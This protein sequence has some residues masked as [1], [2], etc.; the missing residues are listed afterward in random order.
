MDISLQV[1]VNWWE[2][3]T[4]M[5]P[6]PPG[7]KDRWQRA[8][9]PL[10]SAWAGGVPLEFTALYGMRNYGN[11]SW[12]ITHTDRQDTHALSL[13]LNLHQD[14]TAHWPFHIDDVNGTTHEVFLE[15]GEMI[16]YESAACTHGRPVPLVGV[17]FVNMFAHFRPRGDPGW[18]RERATVA[19]APYGPVAQRWVAD[20]EAQWPQEQKKLDVRRRE[21]Y[22]H[23]EE[24]SAGDGGDGDGDTGEAIHNDA[25]AAAVR[26]ELAELRAEVAAGE[27]VEK[28]WREHE[29]RAEQ[30]HSEREAALQAHAASRAGTA[31]AAPKIDGTAHRV[32]DEAEA[33][34]AVGA[35]AAAAGA[36]MNDKGA[37]AAPEE[38]VAAAAARATVVALEA[39][40]MADAAEAELARTRL[41]TAEARAAPGADDE[42]EEE[43]WSRQMNVESKRAA[44]QASGERESIPASWH[45]GHREEASGG[46]GGGD[47]GE[48]HAGEGGHHPGGGGG[49][50]GN[51]EGGHQPGGDAGSG[52]AVGGQPAQEGGGVWRPSEGHGVGM[53]A[54]SQA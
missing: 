47:A 24:T 26:A 2:S 7:Y 30:H 52:D 43:Y 54:V 18:Y 15:P 53:K 28:E 21:H 14:E 35:A 36:E 45:N 31:P 9:M 11:G 38:A 37:V 13:V 27:D 32:T 8:L 6:I 44:G 17:D 3:P 16:F 12:L 29:R 23:L 19:D 25:E 48:N 10:V 34:T 46:E 41:R 42:T 33:A 40:K 51:A 5:L 1:F 49:H 50:P 4:H 20:L 39:A 22:G